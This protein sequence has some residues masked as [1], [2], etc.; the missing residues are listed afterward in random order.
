[1][2]QGSKP[3]LVLGLG[4]TGRSVIA[5][6]IKQG[7]QVFAWAE[8][9]D[10]QALERDFP[11]VR[12]AVGE[13]PSAWSQDFAFFAA[14][15]VS[16]GLPYSHPLVQNAL[17]KIDVYS[18]Y[19]L[20]LEAC[21]AKVVAVT[22][23][24]AKSSVT[25]LLEKIACC[26]GVNVIAGG[27]LG[28]PALDLLESNA[29]CYILECSSFQLQ[30]TKN[31][32][33]DAAVFLNFKP[34]HLD[35]H[36]S[37]EEYLASK[38]KIFDNCKHAIINYDQPDLYNGACKNVSYFAK[39][40]SGKD[41]CGWQHKQND[42]VLYVGKK[43]ILKLSVCPSWV[44][45]YPENIA[46]A[47]AVAAS[48][49]WLNGV[50]DAVAQYQPLPHRLEKVLSHNEITWY[51]D[52]K[53]TNVSAA[54]AG[55]NAIKAIV[56]G[57]VIWICGGLSKGVDLSPLAAA[58]ANVRCV[59]CYGQDAKLLADITNN[60]CPTVVVQDLA[61]AVDVAEQKALSDDAVILSPACS[62]FDQFKNFNERGD[63][64]QKLVKAANYAG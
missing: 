10:L 3:W 30:Y 62:S 26:A 53:A 44:H 28:E 12:F 6:L 38:Q 1:M 2:F 47:V 57:Q 19:D 18:D 49:G 8:S 39:S 56:R 55:V 17:Q 33:C 42:A 11:T 60:I 40:S 41:I 9:A 27:N 32:R 20:F 25:T 64:F 45:V 13:F 37:I 59:I 7:C 31:W 15:V 63:V 46:A 52:S 23:T 4:K 16:P 36:T 43:E 21:T 5:F 51:D 14:A 34:D 58:L 48:Q 54:V 29:D 61:A 50:A 24:N 35:Q 22:G